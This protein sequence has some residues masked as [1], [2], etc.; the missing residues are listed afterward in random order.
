MCNLCGSGKI[1]RILIFLLLLALLGFMCYKYLQPPHEHISKSDEWVVTPAN[2][3][4]EGSRHKICDECGNKFDYE[5]LPLDHQTHASADSYLYE[6]VEPDCV[7]EGYELYKAK[8]T[9]C[10]IDVSDYKKPISALGHV[11]GDSVVENK[12]EKTCDTKGSYDTVTNCRVCGTEIERITSY[13]DFDGHKFS[14]ED[15]KEEYLYSTE[16]L[17]FS[18]DCPPVCGTVSSARVKC[19]NCEV[20]F[21]TSV[22]WDH[23]YENWELAMPSLG[24]FRMIGACS[25][26]AGTE[27]EMSE[28][29][30]LVPEKLS[31]PKCHDRG[32][33]LYTAT[34]IYD[35][36]RYSASYSVFAD[37][38]GYHTICGVDF[39]TL[40]QRDNKG[41]IYFNRSEIDAKFT[42]DAVWDEN[43]FTSETVF[44]CEVCALAIAVRVYNDIDFGEYNPS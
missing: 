26:G 33:T 41:N 44:V 8:C 16:G 28:F 43:G 15:I 2:C 31:D 4:T 29:E 39:R 3:V 17:I 42:R 34:I 13:I 7:N 14:G 12:V 36:I 40:I 18:A 27:I 19:D 1:M 6:R 11:S 23:K 10:G 37:A 9:R 24:E 30:S 21:E 32:E 5:V 38:L 22:R 20:E 25:C 35:G